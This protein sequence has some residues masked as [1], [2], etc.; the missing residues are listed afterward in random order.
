MRRAAEQ[1]DVEAAFCLGNMLLQGFGTAVDPDEAVWWLERCALTGHTSAQCTLGALFLDGQSVPRDGAKAETWLRRAT[2]CGSVV[3]AL[4]LVSLFDRRGDADEAASVLRSFGVDKRHLSFSCLRSSSAT[5][6]LT[7]DCEQVL[8]GALETTGTQGLP[9]AR[10][11]S[12]LD[13]AMS[14]AD[15]GKLEH[16]GSV[17]ENLLEEMTTGH[18]GDELVHLERTALVQNNYATGVLRRQRR[19]EEAEDL[20]IE[21]L[22]SFRTLLGASHHVTAEVAGNLFAIRRARS[23][24]VE[25]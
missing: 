7:E 25:A 14:F 11:Q 16:A 4:D 2:A 17:Y 24:Q 15:R 12:S 18:W 23:D 13:L 19:F 3:A 1:L 9:E 22:T 20:L 10:F 8:Q 5:K 21:A 6:E